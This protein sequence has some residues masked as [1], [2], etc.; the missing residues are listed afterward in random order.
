MHVGASPVLIEANSSME[1]KANISFH[2]RGGEGMLSACTGTIINFAHINTV[3]G[4]KC[5]GMLLCDLAKL[6]T[7]PF[8]SETCTCL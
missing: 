5:G 4:V 7:L 6:I 8:I 1:D 3:A 2:C